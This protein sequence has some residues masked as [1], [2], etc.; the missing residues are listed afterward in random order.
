M[1]PPERPK[2]GKTKS[3]LVYPNRSAAQRKEQKAA[4]KFTQQYRRVFTQQPLM[5]ENNTNGTQKGPQYYQ[6]EGQTFASLPP[7]MI[8]QILQCPYY[9][10]MLKD[11]KAEGVTLPKD[12][13]DQDP[14][15][16]VM[17]PQ[18]YVMRVAA[19]QMPPM[20]NHDVM[21]GLVKEG[22]TAW[23][24]EEICDVGVSMLRPTPEAGH[25]G[26]SESEISDIG[27]QTDTC[28]TIYV[29]KDTLV[30]YTIAVVQ[31]TQSLKF[32]QMQVAL[33]TVHNQ[34]SIETPL[35]ADNLMTAHFNLAL[36]TDNLPTIQSTHAK[37]PEAA[38]AH[39]STSASEQDQET[40]RKT[41][42][43][44]K[45]DSHTSKPRTQP[46][47]AVSPTRRDGYGP[48]CG[49]PAGYES[50]NSWDDTSTIG[51]QDCTRN[52][53][54]STFVAFRRWPNRPHRGQGQSYGQ[55]NNIIVRGGNAPYSRR[56]RLNNADNAHEAN[57]PSVLGHT[58]NGSVATKYHKL[59]HRRSVSLDLETAF[60]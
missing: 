10:Q 60:K 39:P 49:I 34:A 38:T 3:R 44:R 24:S 53:N 29:T 35:T 27:V 6:R 47:R 18:E 28:E 13:L 48:V 9:E 46:T 42:Y 8:Q 31:N 54:I 22:L 40:A 19:G 21:K 52:N 15:T 51:E 33:Q 17:S 59:M 37:E 14:K 7:E 32:E 55:R 12:V 25:T 20:Y 58:E 2:P 56:G 57:K 11:C 30:A 4:W 50:D 23:G 43:K 41:P 16:H 26:A 36:L 1:P 5:V 45:C